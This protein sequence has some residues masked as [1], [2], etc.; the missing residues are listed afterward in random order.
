MQ[1]AARENGVLPH[2]WL[3][4]IMRGHGVR[5]SHFVIKR[6]SDGN[7]VSREKVTELIYP[8]FEERIEAAKAA[9]PFYAPRLATQTVNMKG[10]NEELAKAM[11]AIAERLP[12]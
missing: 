1:E 9:A 8:T 5:Q 6:D 4:T 2:E 11:L 10:G 3:L 7:I 12:V